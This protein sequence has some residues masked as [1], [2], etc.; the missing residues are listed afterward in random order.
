MPSAV[1]CDPRHLPLVRP[2]L[3]RP[4]LGPPARMPLPPTNFR[5]AAWGVRRRGSIPPPLSLDTHP[6]TT[7]LSE[8]LCGGVGVPRELVVLLLGACAL[9][10]CRSPWAEMAMALVGQNGHDPGG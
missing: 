1:T 8:L 6:L 3:V 4:P 10:L 5:P 2:P 7:E 9:V